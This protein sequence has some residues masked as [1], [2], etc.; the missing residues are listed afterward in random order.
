MGE[1]MEKRNPV[2]LFHGNGFDNWK[3]FMET[4]LEEYDFLEL[5]T[6]PYI[7]KVEF[8]GKPA[9]VKTQKQKQ[10][11]QRAKKDKNVARK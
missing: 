4:L 1:L 10:L 3:F 9:E 6:K 2:L 7:Y 5:I 11:D 8:E